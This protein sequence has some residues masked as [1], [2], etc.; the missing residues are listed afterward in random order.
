V[1][2]PIKTLGLNFRDID[3][4]IANK[5]LKIALVTDTHKRRATATSE[6]SP[7]S[8]EEHLY[9]QSIFEYRRV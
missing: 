6:A 1:K 8:E 5:G 7:V 9:R 4:N 2:K 3:D